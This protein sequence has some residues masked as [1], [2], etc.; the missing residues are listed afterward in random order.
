MAI[1]EITV[2]VGSDVS[3]KRKH[4]TVK[5]KY[6]IGAPNKTK[7]IQV[8]RKQALTY[9]SGIRTYKILDIKKIA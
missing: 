9:N 8:L 5:R 3:L 1:Y 7:A 6:T 2:D 4:K